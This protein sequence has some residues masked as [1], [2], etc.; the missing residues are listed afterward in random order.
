MPGLRSV[1]ARIIATFSLLLL[2]LISI[3]VVSILRFGNDQV[4]ADVVEKPPP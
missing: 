1:R 2:L 4:D 3:S